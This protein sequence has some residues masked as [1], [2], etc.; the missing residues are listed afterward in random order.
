MHLREA[1]AGGSAPRH[2]PSPNPLFAGDR[3]DPPPEIP[4]SAVSLRRA[5][6]SFRPRPPR[7]C[8]HRAS[9][10]PA[11][12]TARRPRR[13]L[14]RGSRRPT[15]ASTGRPSP[16]SARDRRHVPAAAPYPQRHSPPGRSLTRGAAAASPLWLLSGFRTQ[17][18]TAAASTIPA[19]DAGTARPPSRVPSAPE[20]EP[21]ASPGATTCGGGPR[22][23]GPLGRARSV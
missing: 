11:A 3:E 17:A 22:G 16:S 7:D 15:P 23:H 21:L 18:P 14:P 8:G 4:G 12:P 20:G 1:H 9:S 5:G 10:R 2:S 13:R 19:A 6:L